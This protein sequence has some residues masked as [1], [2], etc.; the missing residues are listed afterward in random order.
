MPDTVIGRD[1]ELTRIDAFLDRL[2]DGPATLV[3]EGEPGMGKTTLW[4]AAVARAAD[5]SRRRRP[6]SWRSWPSRS[7][8][9][10]PSIRAPFPDAADRQLRRGHSFT[11]PNRPAGVRNGRSPRPPHA[12]SRTYPLPTCVR[13]GPAADGSY[14]RRGRAQPPMPATHAARSLTTS[15]ATCP[16]RAYSAGRA[17]P[18]PAISRWF[19]DG[20]SRIVTFERS[21][22]AM[23]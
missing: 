12:L 8:S 4:R 10:G 23:R 6:L 7:R 19:S 5:R 18:S 1:R 16:G 15:A 2:P 11:S 22:S 13:P 3:L 20:Y 21:P 9:P 14:A 17:G